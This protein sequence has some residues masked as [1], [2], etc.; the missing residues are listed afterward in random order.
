M[1]FNEAKTI[2]REGLNLVNSDLYDKFYGLDIVPVVGFFNKE[3][4]RVE[5]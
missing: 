3:I 2:I 4:D 5:K 1:E